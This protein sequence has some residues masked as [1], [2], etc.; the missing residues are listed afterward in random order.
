MELSSANAE[1]EALVARL[2]DPEA[3]EEYKRSHDR[4][5][6]D[7]FPRLLG[8][9]LVFCGNVVYGKEPSYL[10]FR[11]VEIIARVPY[12]SWEAVIFTLLT[13]FF[14]NEKKALELSKLAKFSRLAQ[15][16]ETMH[17]IV[18]SQLAEREEHAGF[19]RHSLI[20]MLFAFFYFW[21][22]YF[23]YFIRPKWSYELNYLFESH[24]FEQYSRFIDQREQELREKPV[25]SAFLAW[26]GRQPSNQYEF[27]RSVRNDEL[28]HR[29]ESVEHIDQAADQ[30]GRRWIA[31]ALAGLFALGV[32][33]WLW[34]EWF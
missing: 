9:L 12:H 16:N 2:N 18:I 33:L 23:L 28:V 8:K 11:A 7:L 21:A 20:P 15:D 4:Y 10:K 30:K 25:D 1:F 3:L 17:V 27:F 34:H 14:S 22:S 32:S 24:A 13:L 29:N 5:R 6:P 31:L 19:M 26:Y